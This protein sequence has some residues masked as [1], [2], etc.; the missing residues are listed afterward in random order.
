MGKIIINEMQL[1]RLIGDRGKAAT[2][3]KRIKRGKPIF[4]N[5][6]FVF[7]SRQPGRN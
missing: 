1:S 6:D 2:K 3:V 5:E 7:N 4:I